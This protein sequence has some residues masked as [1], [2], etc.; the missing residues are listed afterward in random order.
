MLMGFDFH[1]S[2]NHWMKVTK[3]KAA[4]NHR[5]LVR[6]A[7][8]LIRRHGINGVGVAD[9]GKAAGLTH[10]A[11]YARFASKEALA[12]EALAEANER[13]LAHMIACNAAPT[14]GDYLDLFINKRHRDGL[15]TGCAMAASGSEVA[16]AG[17]SVSRSFSEG[18]DR[19]ALAIQDVLAAGPLSATDR[20]RALAITAAEIGV[21]IV[22]RAVA[23]ANPQLSEEVL[24]AG[25]RVLGEI[26][27]E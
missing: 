24:G 18:F 16:R 22:A 13:S 10:G 12:A 15:A 21:L 6:A 3:D 27:G 25:R 8:K 2:Y 17:K 4:E 23:K 1:Y 14:I 11:V 7:G 9:I 26:C 5:A 19:M 20:E